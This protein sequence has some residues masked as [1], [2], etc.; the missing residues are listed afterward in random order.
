MR[1]S[2]ARA[3]LAAL[4]GSTALG[5]YAQEGGAAGDAPEVPLEQV[6]DTGM[7]VGLAQ[8]A[9]R[10]QDWHAAARIWKRLTVLR[11]QRGDYLYNAAAMYALLDQ[12]SPAYDALLKLQSRGYAYRLDQDERFRNIHGTEVWE[13][14]VTLNNGALDVPF[15]EGSVAFELPASDLLLD[16]MTYDP[17]TRTFLFGSARDG[18]VY[19]RTADGDL[20]S[21]TE[22]DPEHG[23]AITALA[24]DEKNRALWVATASIPHF[25]GFRA[26]HAGKAALVRYDL[27]N[28]RRVAAYAVPDD[29]L[30]HVPAVL[31][32]AGNGQVFI[33]EGLRGQLF[34]FDGEQIKP[35]LA[36]PRLGGIRGLALSSNGRILYFADV[37]QGVFGLDLTRSSAF[38]LKL[39]NNVVM[40]GVEGLYA[41]EGQLVAVQSG[42]VPRRVMRLKL[43]EDGLSAE[44]GTPIEANQPAFEAPT[45][46]VVQ[47]DD[48][49]FI[50]NSQRHHY[51]GYGLPKATAGKEKLKVYRTPIRFNWDFKPPEMPEGVRERL[52]GKPPGG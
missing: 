28:G 43:A 1:T 7:L 16:S 2:F 25:Q 37:D 51:D 52:L 32:V 42:M 5:V 21:L 18:K 6:Q 33:G 12:K 40:A 17:L 11:P 34:Q 26:A 23:G 27:R 8:Q 10:S 41:Y 45:W 24:V 48:L 19:R 30:P 4:I 29:R 20:E 39:P 13:Y 49:Y 22:P 15:G 3:L 14:L 35:L 36:E 46:G 47:G 38:D 50:A 31:T 44:Q 9:E